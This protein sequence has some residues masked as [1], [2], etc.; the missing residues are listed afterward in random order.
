[1]TSTDEEMIEEGPYGCIEETL[2][3]R[4]SAHYLQSIQNIIFRK[5]TTLQVDSLRKVNH[6]VHIYVLK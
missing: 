5:R 3:P 6:R 4:L 2:V 1:M